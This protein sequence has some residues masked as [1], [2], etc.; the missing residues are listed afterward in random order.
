MAEPDIYAPL[1]RRLLASVY[2]GLLMLALWMSALFLDVMIRD[3]LLGLPLSLAALRALTFLIWLGFFGWF[4]LHGG[5]TLGMR[6]WRLRLQR[7]DGLALAWPDVLLRYG[8]AW[9]SWGLA[10]LGMLWCLVDRQRRAWHDIAA[11][12]VVIVLPKKT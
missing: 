12:T 9:F 7:S 11:G 4:W 10:G 3:S 6:A 8:V 5:Q 2:D 1:W